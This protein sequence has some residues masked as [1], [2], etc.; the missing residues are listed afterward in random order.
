MR[1][2]F[3]ASLALFLMWSVPAF[4]QGR[5]IGRVVD[6]SGNPVGAA[7]VSVSGALLTQAAITNSSGYYTFLAV[8]TG[9]YTVKAYK[10]GMPSWS[11]PVVVSNSMIRQDIQLA[12][13]APVEVAEEK[14]VKEP[15]AEKPRSAEPVKKAEPVKPQPES[16]KKVEPAKQPEPVKQPEKQPDSKPVAPN[17]AVQT[18]PTKQTLAPVTMALNAE[19][20]DAGLKQAVEEAK[21]TDASEKAILEKRP[22]ILGGMTA[23]YSKLQY[24]SYAREN[25]IE[26][27]V[28]ARVYISKT[29]AV[30]KVTI[31]KAPDRSLSEEVFRVLSE[32]VKFQA[33]SAGNK[34]ADGTIIVL[35][36]FNLK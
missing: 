11:K 10:R 15:K 17:V 34:A 36:D 16:V 4:S 13:A 6:D 18:S 8:P 26:G 12:V 5:L 29:S 35:V 30:S 1:H 33:G 22:E 27:S 31:I 19:I 23:I 7:T 24:P 14:E 25:Q 20:T 9:D 28:M 2:L 32:D 3:Y 21:A